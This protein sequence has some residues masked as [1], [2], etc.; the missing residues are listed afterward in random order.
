MTMNLLDI[1]K[2][3]FT[4]ELIGKIGN[5]LGENER[6]TRSAVEQILPTLLGGLIAKSSTPAGANSLINMLNDRT[7]DGNVLGDL[8]GIFAGGDRSNAFMRMGSSVLGNIFGDKVGGVIDLI[9]GGTG[10]R[11]ESSNNL[12]SFLAPIVL[13]LLGKTKKDQGLNASGLLSLILGQGSFLKNVLPAGLGSILGFSGGIDSLVKTA[14]NNLSGTYKFEGVDATTTSGSGSSYRATSAT[15]HSNN[16]NGGGGMGWLKWLL[17]LL[18]LAALLYFW[19]SCGKKV[20]NAAQ[21]TVEQV[22]DAAN[23]AGDAAK[24]AANAAGDAAQ[25]V[26]NAAGDAAQNAANA[27]GNAATQ[28]WAA[29]GELFKVKLPN[30]VEL[31]VPKLGVENRLITWISDKTKVVDKTTWFDFDRLLFETNQAVLK[32]ESQEQLKNVAEIL[33]AFPSVEVKIGGYTDNSGD[34]AKNLKL[35]QD[36]ANSVMAELVKL[37]IEAK[38]MK[39]EGYGIEHPV[40]DNSTPEGREK[41]RR[42]SL[43][44]TKK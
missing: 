20:E 31:N 36:R 32:P 2:G 27:A 28:A 1:L 8:M 34:A 6:S 14:Y 13:G 35:S 19:R 3:Y 24:N 43:R 9:A 17:P 11:K 21:N 18:L 26:A 15:T 38:R 41:N 33:K 44:V 16:D 29:L 39:A 4:N 30:N 22:G 23:A 40:A 37:G 42:V 7:H 25:N 12:L 10:L 5:F